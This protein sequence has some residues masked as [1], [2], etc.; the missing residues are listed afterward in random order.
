[1]SSV[2]ATVGKQS[3]GLMQKCLNTSSRKPTDCF[4]ADAM[5]NTTTLQLKY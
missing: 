1:M 4:P 3:V 5:T 2:I